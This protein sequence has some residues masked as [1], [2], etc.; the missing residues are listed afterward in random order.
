MSED[1]TIAEARAKLDELIDTV[2]S[3]GPQTVTENGR[4]VAVVVSPQDGGEGQD[5]YA[6]AEQRALA[7]LRISSPP[8]RC[9]IPG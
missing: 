5:L 7:P 1:W 6:V 9:A 3:H 8:L 4:A 2:G